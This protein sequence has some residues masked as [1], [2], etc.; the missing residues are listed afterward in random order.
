MMIVKQQPSACLHAEADGQQPKG[1]GC[2]AW[3]WAHRHDQT[4]PAEEK[5][6]PRRG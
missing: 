1:E 5:A 3:P 2:C 4:A 6:A